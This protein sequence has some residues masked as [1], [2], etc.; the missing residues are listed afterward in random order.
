MTIA[1]SIIISLI[2]E[3][4]NSTSAVIFIV[5]ILL[6]YLN[7][8]EENEFTNESLKNLILALIL[9]EMEKFSR[10]TSVDEVWISRDRIPTGIYVFLLRAEKLLFRAEIG[11]I[12]SSYA[13]NMTAARSTTM[14][15]GLS[16]GYSVNNEYHSL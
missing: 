4:I 16:G 14:V 13:V 5:T 12:F 10:E 6:G 15:H 1:N 8:R 7:K 9:N 11:V 2:Y 3:N